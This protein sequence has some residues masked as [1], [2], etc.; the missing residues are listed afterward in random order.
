MSETNTNFNLPSA[1]V[2]NTTD[3]G[4]I[5]F[6]CQV[7]EVDSINLKETD[8]YRKNANSVI[9]AMTNNF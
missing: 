8:R 1:Q 5:Q 4:K 9:M 3:G 2:K 6:I 7:R